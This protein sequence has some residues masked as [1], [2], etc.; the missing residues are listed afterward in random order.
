MQNAHRSQEAIEDELASWIARRFPGS[1]LGDIAWDTALVVDAVTDLGLAEDASLAR[2]GL[3][4]NEP[5][6]LG[7][8]D[9]RCGRFGERGPCGCEPLT[10]HTCPRWHR[11]SD[12]WCIDERPHLAVDANGYVWHVY[13]EHWSMARTNPDNSPV[14][15][16][17]TYYVPVVSD[18]SAQVVTT[19]EVVTFKYDDEGRVVSQTTETVTT[20]TEP[21]TA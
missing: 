20:S 8:R 21:V 18:A 4:T 19:T 6:P 1:T 10:A 17:V 11:D 9:A 2:I 7:W 3:M 5:C 14:P 12:G 15:Q 16:P 13:G